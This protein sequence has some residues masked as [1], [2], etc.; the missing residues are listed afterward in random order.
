MERITACPTS[1]RFAAAS[2]LSML[3]RKKAGEASSKVGEL[4]RFTTT[5]APWSAVSSP[6][7]VI[8][9]TPLDREY[10]IAS[11]PAAFRIVTTCDPM[12]PVP[13]IT[14]IFIASHTFPLIAC[15]QPRQGRPRVCDRPT[16]SA[17]RGRRRR[18]DRRLVRQ[19]A[20][21]PHHRQRRDQA[22]HRDEKRGSQP[23]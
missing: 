12:S 5:S 6:S 10:G 16:G 15:R 8:R 20:Q 21:R 4:V 18:D 11:C 13:P 9:L 23:D 1:A 2:K 22:D 14:A 19:P 7:P 17:R 3:V